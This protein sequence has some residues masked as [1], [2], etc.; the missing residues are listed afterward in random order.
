MPRL[1]TPLGP[2]SFRA[3]LLKVGA[4]LLCHSLWAR[5]Q[6]E[7]FSLLATGFTGRITPCRAQPKLGSLQGSSQITKRKY[8]SYFMRQ[9]PLSCR[10]Q[11]N[12]RATKWLSLVFYAVPVTPGNSRIVAGYSTNALPPRAKRVLQSGTPLC[13]AG[14]VACGQCVGWRL[15]QGGNGAAGLVGVAVLSRA[16]IWHDALSIGLVQPPCC[17]GICPLL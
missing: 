16:G 8:L 2:H 11:P 12:R 6:S 4:A 3:R 1:I 14:G 7:P 9:T 10:L 15:C 5:H 13:P 17:L